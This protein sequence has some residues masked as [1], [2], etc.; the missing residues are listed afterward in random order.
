MGLLTLL[1][2]GF[3][4]FWAL[5]VGA[6][7]HALLYPPRRTFAWCVSRGQPCDPHAA[8]PPR[9]FEEASIRDPRRPAAVLPYWIIEGE[10]PAGPVLIFSHGWA[11]SK[12]S[13]LQRLDAL[14]PA[15][16][17]I[18]AWDLPGHGDA[19][20]GSCRLGI[21]ERGAL[22]ELVRTVH[23][24]GAAGAPSQ[25]VLYGFS[26]GAGVSL[27]A[28]AREPGAVAAVIAEAP[29]RVPWTPARNVMDQKGLPR[30]LNLRPALC[31]A[32]A[33]LGA[34]PLWRGFDRAALARGVRC[35]LL[36]VH[37]AD[38]E[39]CPIEDGRDIAGAAPRARIVELPQTGHLD[40]WVSLPPRGEAAGAVRAFL[41]ELAPA[42]HRVP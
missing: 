31:L 38:D 20:P 16:S 28:A 12:Q 33:V 18:I 17:K 26:L 7:L 30:R 35:P 2:A 32:G 22:L 29:Y 25:V 40:A 5:L 4:V 11:E 37:G 1:A 6:T 36:V 23:A 21:D 10:N 8:S 9:P 41:F 34:N 14:A 3:V 42:P 24:W 27:D 19:S 15:C 13:V 39:M